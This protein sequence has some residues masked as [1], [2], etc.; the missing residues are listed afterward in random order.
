MANPTGGTA[1]GGPPAAPVFALNPS[2]AVADLY[3]FASVK[4]SK[5]YVTATASLTTKHDGT[6]KTLVYVLP[7][8]SD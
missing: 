3:D 8:C 2:K 4:D 7:L 5:L 6:K 1:A